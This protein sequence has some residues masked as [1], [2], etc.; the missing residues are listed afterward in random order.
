MK[1]VIDDSKY[2]KCW[3]HDKPNKKC[4]LCNGTGKFKEPHYYIIT[5]DKQG[6]KIA[7]DCDGIN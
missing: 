2:T 1:T 3:G 6:N 4:K 7:F 5:Q